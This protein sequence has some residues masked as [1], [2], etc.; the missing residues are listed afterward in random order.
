MAVLLNTSRF[1]KTP[2]TKTRDG[3]DTYGIIQGFD[4]L[5]DIDGDNIE[6]FLVDSCY[7]GRPD[8]IAQLFYGNPHLEW[9]IVFA[10]R[11]KNT[12]NWPKAGSTIKIPRNTFVR[13]L[14]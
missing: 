13:S 7:S 9:V 5:R 12:L 6:S 8:L 1:I 2:L 3:K 4:S 10:N 11:P 14:F